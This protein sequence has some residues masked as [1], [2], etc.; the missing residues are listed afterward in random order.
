MA[1]RPPPCL[2]PPG[3]PR[4][5]S[6]VEEERYFRKG[7]GLR[8]EVRDQVHSEFHSGLVAR[9][10]EAGFTLRFGVTTFRLAREFG[11]CYGVER[12]VDYAY[13]T[14]MRFPG[15]RI[16][17]TGEIIH[18][19][20]V[21]QRLRDL[22]L[23]FLGDAEVPDVAALAPDDVVLLPAFGVSA[24]QFD[25]LRKTGA[26]VVDTTCGS[27]LNVWKNVERY[28][29][30]GFT[31]LVHG[32]VSHEETRATV[33]RVLLGTNGRYLVVFDLAEARLVADY[34]RASRGA[35]GEPVRQAQGGADR[36]AFLA[37]FA[38]AASPGFDPDRD[39]ERIG[40]ANQ[41][42]MLSS[43]SLAIARLVG[44]AM[45]ERY[46][47]EEGRARF[48]AF[49]TICSA[50]Q[51]RQDALANLI[52]ETPDLLIVI[53]GYN[54]SNTGHLVE[55]AQGRVPAF[56]I[57]GPRCLLDAE[58]IRHRPVGHGVPAQ[59]AEVESTGWLPPGPLTIG[60]TAGASTPDV[61]IGAVVERI[62]ALRGTPLGPAGVS[63]LGPS[64]T[65]SA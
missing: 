55:M 56:H 21:N 28:A 4:A 65:A 46:G 64:P 59:V 50:T 3:R 39:L 60:L 37:R 13:E 19:P 44:E 18:N 6:A 12:A 40:V 54:S 58:R 32:K 8:A 27:V 25:A 63:D 49:D 29:R 34:I 22:G 48:R 14:L 5:P 57:E 30:D 24:P 23:K 38:A 17:L 20:G 52:A 7:L 31:S 10:R 53:G 11:F 1:E 26:V 62:L 43:E 41:T 45:V 35:G 61:V 42:T 51:D 15:R 2:L 9:F 16:V 36:A 47:A 33:S